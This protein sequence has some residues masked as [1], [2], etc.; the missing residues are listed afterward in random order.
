MEDPEILPVPTMTFVVFAATEDRWY[1]CPVFL[2]WR[3]LCHF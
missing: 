3:E 1:T 2:F